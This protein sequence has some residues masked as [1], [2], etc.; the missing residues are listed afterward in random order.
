MSPILLIV[1]YFT[2]IP[3]TVSLT[4]ESE[5]AYSKTFAPAKVVFGYTVELV[6]LISS[7]SYMLNNGC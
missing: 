5:V 7:S 4:A 6:K 1:L 2:F 3:K